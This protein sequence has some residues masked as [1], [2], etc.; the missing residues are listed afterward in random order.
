VR[1]AI[2]APPDR[3]ARLLVAA[4][5]NRV[6]IAAVVIDVDTGQVLARVQVPDAIKS[7]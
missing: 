4:R 3:A 1:L 5:G 7:P 2:D 6:A